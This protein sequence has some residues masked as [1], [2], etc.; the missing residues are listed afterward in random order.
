MAMSGQLLLSLLLPPM[1][2]TPNNLLFIDF[3]LIISTV[4]IERMIVE[5]EDGDDCSMHK[6]RGATVVF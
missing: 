3:I 4:N 2:D 1:S 6:Q 5:Y